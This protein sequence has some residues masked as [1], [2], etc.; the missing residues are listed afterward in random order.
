MM[1]TVNGSP[2]PW[3]DGMTVRKILEEKRYTFP[4]L[5]VRI[6]GRLVPRS[7]YGETTVPDGA[8]VD[9]MHLMSGG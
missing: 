2:H 8:D 7:D 1:I 3:H 5:V 4:L 6:D 9:V